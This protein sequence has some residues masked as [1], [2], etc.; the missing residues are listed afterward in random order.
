MNDKLR[1]QNSFQ[2]KSFEKQ[3]HS[4]TFKIFYLPVVDAFVLD[5]ADSEKC[6]WCYNKDIL[7]M[8]RFSK[9]SWLRFTELY[10]LSNQIKLIYL[11]YMPLNN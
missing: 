2:W 1:N 7:V 10:S 5:I 8:G 4:V 3:F 11:P 6:L 9:T